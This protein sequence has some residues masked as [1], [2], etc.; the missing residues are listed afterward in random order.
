VHEL[1]NRIMQGVDPDAPDASIRMAM[2]M[3]ALVPWAWLT[4]LTVFFVLVGGWLG[5]RRGR[6]WQGLVWAF[7][8]GPVG[9]WVVLRERRRGPL[10]PPLPPVK[11]RPG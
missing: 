7:V 10:P 4:W 1:L 11:R 5:Y 9:W 2:N 6:L 3:M 8:L